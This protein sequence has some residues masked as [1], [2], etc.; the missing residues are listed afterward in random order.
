MPYK[1][2]KFGQTFSDHMLEI[3]WSNELG[4]QDPVIKP[5]GNLSVH[6][7]TSALHYGLQAFEGTILLLPFFGKKR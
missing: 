7:A 5:F 6:P 4:W 2:L 1:E 3:D